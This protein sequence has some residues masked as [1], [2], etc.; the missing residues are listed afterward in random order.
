[1]CYCRWDGYVM[2][3]GMVTGHS[4]DA[5]ARNQGSSRPNLKQ[6]HPLNLIEKLTKAKDQQG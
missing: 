6:D 3:C 4:L 2:Q 5:P 1:M